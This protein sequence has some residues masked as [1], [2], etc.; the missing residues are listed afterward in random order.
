M[1]TFLVNKYLKLLFTRMP[2]YLQAVNNKPRIRIIEASIVT[3]QIQSAT[4]IILYRQY[5]NSLETVHT[6]AGF[7]ENVVKLDP[8]T[9][10]AH[11]KLFAGKLIIMFIPPTR[12]PLNW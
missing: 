1:I 5:E 7:L 9:N 2:Q 10:F 3:I 4:E 6:Y 11:M 8:L 12:Q